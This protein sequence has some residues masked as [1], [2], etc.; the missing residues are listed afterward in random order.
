M[1][2]ARYAPLLALVLAVAGLYGCS[3]LPPLGFS[4]S[5]AQVH[6]WLTQ[7]RYDWALPAL[8]RRVQRQHSASAR[9]MLKKAQTA[10]A[11]YDR[12]TAAQALRRADQR[13]WAG[14]LHILDTGL[15]HYPDGPRLRAAHN[16]VRARQS[17]RLEE[18]E[19]QLML[20]KGQWLLQ[21]TPIRAELARTDPENLNA[22]WRASRDQGELRKTAE[23]LLELGSHALTLHNLDLAARCLQLADRLHHTQR[24]G[25]ALDRLAREQR[26][27]IERAQAQQR[28]RQAHQ[29]MSEMQHAMA[30][31]DLPTA[32]DKLQELSRIDK[33]NPK[34]QALGAALN[35]AIA[36]KVA[37]LTHKGDVLYTAGR[38]T[39]A[40]RAWEAGIALDPHNRALN[41]RIRR[42]DRVLRKLNKL[43][44]KQ[45]QSK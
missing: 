19:V 20:A 34:L 24:S 31:A 25:K 26:Q 14:A 1:S 36:A 22:G 21:S 16:T 33:D 11:A 45:H 12:K 41:G 17:K 18:L 39:A 35:Q 7:H 43:R 8:K 44:Q 37:E 42:A 29:L 2:L 6:H 4:P 5:D 9:A 28:S 23:R 10:A 15:A 3:T 32:R 40:K 27:R 30:N 38:I 13:D